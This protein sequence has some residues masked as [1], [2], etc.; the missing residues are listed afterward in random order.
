MSI[1]LQRPM[2]GLA[3]V[4]YASLPLLLFL[5]GCGPKEVAPTA[6][7]AVSHIIVFDD[8]GQQVTRVQNAK[9]LDDVL[10]DIDSAPK[11][12]T[13]WGWNGTGILL[14]L[15]VHFADGR[16][17]RFVLLRN[18]RIVEIGRSPN[19]ACRVVSSDKLETALL[20]RAEKEKD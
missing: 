20:Q 9:L 2:R 13:G 8:T 4:L 18:D 14:K 12:P 11:C 1:E 15:S 6:R 5:P 19:D 7:K 3:I 16:E 10:S 17:Q